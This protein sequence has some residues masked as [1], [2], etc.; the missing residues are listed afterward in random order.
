[1]RTEEYLR[2]L[3]A[4]I[5]EAVRAGRAEGTQSLLSLCRALVTAPNKDPP[6]ESRE[7]MFHAIADLLSLCVILT[8]THSKHHPDYRMQVI[9]F[10]KLCN[11]FS[12]L[13]FVVYICKNVLF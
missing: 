2:P 11:Y 7:R 10:F 8:A 9:N 6:N 12:T 13:F 1:M 4:L 3:R 5:R